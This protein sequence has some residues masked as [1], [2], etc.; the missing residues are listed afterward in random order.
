MATNPI[1]S[2][3]GSS[4]I[5]GSFSSG[6]IEI[7]A[8]VI[9]CEWVGDTT[10]FTFAGEENGVS[11]KL[12]LSPERD[13]SFFEGLH[14]NMLLSS[15]AIGARPSKAGVVKFIRQHNLERHFRFNVA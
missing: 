13:I 14:I 6:G 12:L 8:P 7:S 3:N 10:V 2:L 1:Y 4:Y 9:S 11:L 5:T 15:M